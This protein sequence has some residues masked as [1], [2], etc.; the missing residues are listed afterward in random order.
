MHSGSLLQ[1]VRSFEVME[2][3]TISVTGGR[4]FFSSDEWE[5]TVLGEVSTL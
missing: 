2:S 5:N 4:L 1:Q 3:F